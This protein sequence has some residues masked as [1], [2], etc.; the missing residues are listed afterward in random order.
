MKCL[1]CP[2]CG[3]PNIQEKE[4]WLQEIDSVAQTF[5]TPALLTAFE[6]TSCGWLAV[7]LGSVA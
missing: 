2:Q 3:Y 1:M 6:C 7:A 5:E 4:H